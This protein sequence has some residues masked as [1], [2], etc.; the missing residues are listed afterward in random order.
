M[1]S[2]VFTSRPWRLTIVAGDLL[3]GSAMP[4]CDEFDGALG[5]ADFLSDLRAE[6]AEASKRAEDDPLK[7]GVEEVTVDLDVAFTIAKKGEASARA[8][9]RFWVFASV[10]GG[11]KGQRSSERVSTQHLT[12]TLKPR[13]E[14]VITDEHGRARVIRRGVD[15]TGAIGAGEEHPDLPAPGAGGQ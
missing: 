11:V 10:E 2:M 13:S 7:L 4:E 1:V 12:L 8:G 6:L 5:L 15:V 9:A 14:E 3:R